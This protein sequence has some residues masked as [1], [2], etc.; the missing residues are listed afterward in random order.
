VTSEATIIDLTVPI[1][2]G[3]GRLDIPARFGTPFTFEERGW[4]GS[5]FELFCHHGTHVDAPNHFVEGGDAIHAV[6]LDRLMGP[7]AVVELG[8][9]G[10]RA[11]IEGDT[12]EDRGGHVERGDIIILRTGW[13]DLHWGTP[14]FWNEGP[15]LAESG[16]AWIVERGLKAVVYDF[17]EEL[18]IRT[19][20]FRG[21]DCVI[22]NRILGN[23]IYNIEYVR[24]LG[25]IRSERVAL[26]ALPLPLVGLDGSPTRVVA[27]EGVEVPRDFTIR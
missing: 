7:G 6:P 18:A 3:K 8:D 26:L 24:N 25:A 12:L 9:H 27:L 2:H 14:T 22:H 5:T 21:E 23:D 4:Q 15:Y 19:P 17:S 10:Q 11:G 20:G 13:S 16:A 1:E